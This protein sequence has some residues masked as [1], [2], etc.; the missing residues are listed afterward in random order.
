[1]AEYNQEQQAYR[2][3][4]KKNSWRLDTSRIAELDTTTETGKIAFDEFKQTQ[5]I[6]DSYFKPEQP[7]QPTIQ[8]VITQ[9]PTQEQPEQPTQPTQPEPKQD[10]KT[11]QDININ[12]KEDTEPF[13]SSK[14]ISMAEKFQW[15]DGNMY[16]TVRNSDN[17]LTTID[18][19]TGKPVTWKYTDTQRQQIKESFMQDNSVKALDPNML[20]SSLQTGQYISP[21]QQN[22]PEYRQAY[23]R[24]ADLNMYSSMSTSDLAQAIQSG[25]FLPGTTAYNDVKNQNPKLVADAE[26]QQAINSINQPKTEVRDM[27]TMISE[28]LTK[29][30][31]PEQTQ[32]YAQVLSGNKDVQELN[33]NL[34][35][36]AE[37]MAEY[38]DQLEYSVEDFR[39]DIGDRTVTSGYA[40]YKV[41]E[42][43]REITRAYNLELAK[44]N[45]TAGQLQTISENIKYE[46]ES[47]ALRKQNELANMWTAIWLYQDLTADERALA[48]SQ[49]QLEQQY[50][51][52]YGDLDSENPTLQNIA[53]QNAVAD[54]YNK[55]PLPGM[56]SQAIKVQK[57]QNL[58]AQG[59]SGSQAIAQVEGEIRNTQ[60]YRD[61]IAWDTSTTQDWA[62]LDDGTLFNKKT[63]ETKGV[64]G[65]ITQSN[66]LWDLRHLASQYPWQAWA[67]NNNPAGITWNSN[68]EN[69]KGTA[70]LFDEA[71][72]KYSKG[73]SRPAAE[74]GNYVTFDTMADGL[75]AQRILMS[76]TY[77][78]ST[79]WEMLQS[80]VWTSEWPNYAKQVAGNAGI[81]L[82]VKVKDLS[83]LELAEL[84]GA[85]IQK[86]S[87]W[88]YDLL[89]NQPDPSTDFDPNSLPIYT[90]YLQTGKIGTNKDEFA[91]IIREFGGV[92]NFKQQAENYNNSENWPRQKELDTVKW[93]KTQL[94][95]FISPENE[96]VLDNSIWSIQQAWTPWNARRREDYLAN[97][98]NF[99]SWLTLN[100]LIEAKGAWATF[101]ALSN[102]EL[103]MLQ[104]SASALNKL[105]VRPW[106]EEYGTTFIKWTKENFEKKVQELI[107]TYDETIRKKE[108]QMGKINKN[109]TMPEWEWIWTVV[110]A[111]GNTYTY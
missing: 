92:E 70:A 56:E 40:S 108:S 16:Q 84:Q 15:T 94:E 98:D 50:A 87:P 81:D 66:A 77:W 67:K 95:S 9:Q 7:T 13:D 18:T 32:S 68:F 3:Y 41:W 45:A 4:I 27:Q 97:I 106:D 33:A 96:W 31:T 35:K 102:E 34:A 42:R 52:T 26:R 51:Y 90:N 59:M 28:Y 105:F 39:K 11:V 47:E 58:I 44:Y 23:N 38:K 109:D 78:E 14:V 17:T 62:K 71:G 101:G 6:A 20:F 72:I 85:K 93:L 57:V 12:Y 88:L 75:A 55:Y 82:N 10:W 83:E 54:M 76:G 110:S 37:Q 91:E 80:W 53:I 103:K 49:K 73:T 30:M 21:Q 25:Q 111:S 2:D 100:T 60:R 61:Y 99:L 43:T 65:S 19:K 63:G 86:E 29:L 104:N 5:S 89:S 46:M 48:L 1:M 36:S 69:W 74:W 22:T 24:Y 79:V 107:N 8:P 64:D